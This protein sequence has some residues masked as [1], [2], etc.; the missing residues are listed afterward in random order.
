MI[1]LISAVSFK[2]FTILSFFY[3]NKGFYN[4]ALKAELNP[5]PMQLNLPTF[6]PFDGISF[7]REQA[8]VSFCFKTI[9]H[10]LGEKG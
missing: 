4:S 2:K 7:L 10:N 3:T 6:C 8:E 1:H 9:K 5:P